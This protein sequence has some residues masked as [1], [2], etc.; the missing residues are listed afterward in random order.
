MNMLI[1]EVCSVL[2]WIS[3]CLFNKS[4]R[5]QITVESSFKWLTTMT[6][7]LWWF[8]WFSAMKYVINSISLSALMF[9]WFTLFS[10]LRDA[11]VSLT[12]VLSSQ[13]LH[14][15]HLFLLLLHCWVIAV[16]HWYQC[17][18]ETL[19]KMK[20]YLLQMIWNTS[21]SFHLLAWTVRCALSSFHCFI[22]LFKLAHSEIYVSSSM[23]SSHLIA[24]I[25]HLKD[26]LIRRLYDL[27]W[28]SLSDILTSDYQML[29]TFKK[30]VWKSI[31]L[32]DNCWCWCWR[33][34]DTQEID[35]DL[36][37]TWLYSLF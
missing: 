36:F 23:F 21:Q 6:M 18:S 7:N 3:V 25:I 16:R 10:L 30:N 8:S 31:Q 13:W 24:A 20:I 29:M 5:V 17:T 19:S 35:T 28:E 12:A 1:F 22:S 15:A 32:R 34:L 37:I 26:Q 33:K 9:D 27:K 2:F 14:T 4:C 11:D